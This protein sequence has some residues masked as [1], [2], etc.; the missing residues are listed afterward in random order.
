MHTPHQRKIED[1]KRSADLSQQLLIDRV[2]EICDSRVSDLE[3]R[4]ETVAKN[5]RWI[6]FLADQIDSTARNY[7]GDPGMVRIFGHHFIDRCRDR[8]P[9]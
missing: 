4:E 1:L 2:V 8:F 5:E 3:E 6:R 9:G 7:L